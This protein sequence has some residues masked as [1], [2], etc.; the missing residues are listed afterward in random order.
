MQVKRLLCFSFLA[1]ILNNLAAQDP[2]FSQYYAAPMY[3]NPGLV[4]INQKGSFGVNYRNQWPNI[5]ANFETYSFYVDNHFEDIY[6]SFGIIFTTDREGIVGLQS[7]TIGLQYAYQVELTPQWTFRPGVEVAYFIRD[8]NFSKL[9]FGDQFDQNG[10]VNPVSA[11][12]LNTGLKAKFFNISF[13][14]IFYTPYMWVG[15]AVHHITEPNQSLVGGD[16]KLPRRSSIHGGYRIPFGSIS[17]KS[18]ASTDSRERSITPTF[19]YR[20]QG[21]FDQLDLGAFV[22]LDPLLLGVWYRGIPVRK[23][24]GVANSESIIFMVGLQQER[25]TIGYSF[26]YT[27]SDLGIGTG[28][29]HEISFTYTFSLADPRKP[30]KDVRELRCPVPFIF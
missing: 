15:G 8:L 26:D 23:I 12:T 4:G 9:T 17:A 16:A 3:L 5:Q 19:N 20:S 29:A 24:D 30:P 21:N 28:G 1:L 11:E 6:S 10:L 25:T 18:A 14:G 27:I 2:Q 7:N 13:G 22:T